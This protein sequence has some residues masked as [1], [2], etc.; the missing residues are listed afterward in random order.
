MIRWLAIGLLFLSMGAS[1]QGVA[2]H[3]DYQIHYNAVPSGFLTVDVAQSYGILRSRNRGVLLVSVKRDNQAVS[4]RVE[5]QVGS[6]G[7]RLEVL[8]MRPVQ[9]SGIIS[10]LGSFTI[11]DGE[12]RHFRLHIAPTGGPPIDL[13]FSQQF[14]DR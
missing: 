7:D 9:T 3:G 10:Y 8:E 14:F 4:A 1:A 6:G 12:S 2:Q 5:A 13:E 11:A